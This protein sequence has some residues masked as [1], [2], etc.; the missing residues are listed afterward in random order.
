[1][2][3]TDMLTFQEFIMQEPYR[4]IVLRPTLRLCPYGKQA[5][6]Q[7][8]DAS[9]P[10]CPSWASWASWFKSRRIAN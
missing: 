10:T 6:T 8:D 3:G 7:P 1:M 2:F 4:L 9:A 5:G